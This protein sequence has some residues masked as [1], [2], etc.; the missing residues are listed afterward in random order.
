M[1]GTLLTI[2]LLAFVIYLVGALA[3]WWTFFGDPASM[4]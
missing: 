3:S 2:G 4:R 1:T